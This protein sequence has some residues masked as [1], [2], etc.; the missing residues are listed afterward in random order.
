MPAQWRQTETPCF[1]NYITGMLMPSGVTVQLLYTALCGT[2][3]HN[4][5]GAR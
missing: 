3:R 4:V 2:V 1:N 5:N